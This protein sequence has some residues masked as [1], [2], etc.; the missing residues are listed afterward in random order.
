VYGYLFADKK[1][2]SDD[3]AVITHDEDM[4][5]IAR[6]VRNAIIKFFSNEPVT[7]QVENDMEQHNLLVAG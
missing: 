6:I 3:I 5:H 2:F 1:F 7:I 4:D